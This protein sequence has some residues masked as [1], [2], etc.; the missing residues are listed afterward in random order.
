MR[1]HLQ[2][3]NDKIDR[4]LA[5]QQKVEDHSQAIARL[6]TVCSLVAAGIA[7]AA[8]VLKDWIFRHKRGGPSEVERMVLPT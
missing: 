8:S 2:A 5:L 1:A 6:K 4:L 7:L 3:I